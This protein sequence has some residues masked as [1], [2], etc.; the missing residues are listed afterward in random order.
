MKY[1]QEQIDAVMRAFLEVG[2]Y[3]LTDDER[4]IIDYFDG[5]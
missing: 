1:T 5:A 3:G 4:A 2:Y